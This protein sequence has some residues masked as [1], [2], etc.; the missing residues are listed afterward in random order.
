MA[1]T[2]L[3]ES[4]IEQGEK[5]LR[6]LDD[7][8]L[9][10]YAAYWMLSEESESWILNFASKKLSVLGL[11][12]SYGRL[13][14]VLLE[15]EVDIP[16]HA[17]HVLDPADRYLNLLTSSVRVDNSRV[18]FSNNVIDG[19][20]L[21]EMVIYRATRPVSTRLKGPSQTAKPSGR[22]TP[23]AKKQKVR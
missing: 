11:R 6:L 23:A 5:L 2:T 15:S 1:A 17:M 4:R 18:T 19:I 13:Q 14:S 8:D 10:I 16:L 7:A 20:R 3:V 9:K 12:G 21:P 22:F